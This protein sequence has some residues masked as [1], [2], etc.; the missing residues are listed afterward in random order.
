[1][2][3]E[4]IN[5]NS[6]SLLEKAE[7]FKKNADYTNYFI[8]LTMA[9]NLHNDK[10]I[11]MFKK[12]WEVFDKQD[13]NITRHFYQETLNFPYSVNNMGY[14]Y[15]FGYGVLPILEKAVELYQIGVEMKCDIAIHNLAV[16]YREGKGVQQNI[17]KAIELFELA[18]S[19][20]NSSSMN[21]LAFT[22][23]NK[24]KNYEMAIKYY[25]MA[26]NEKHEAALKNLI[27]LYQNNK[28][29]DKK[30]VIDYFMG[31]CQEKYLKDIYNYNEEYIQVL[32]ENYDMK[33]EN[34]K[35]KTENDEMRNHI[36]AS[37]DG[38][39]YFEALQE[40]KKRV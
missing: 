25:E 2:F 35:L 9:C 7:E 30:Y 13:F 24:L 37:P 8:H 28:V 32:R 20:G 26:I 19:L 33:K 18:V 4:I 12:D 40:W 31:I 39:L 38:P 1:M 15:E 5:Y 11:E 36:L 27:Y 34:E 22:Y 29:K 3:E 10:A 14:L 17:D 23:S 6:T 16:S 21:S